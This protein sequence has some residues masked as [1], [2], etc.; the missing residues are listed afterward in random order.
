MQL[1]QTHNPTAAAAHALAVAY[2][3]HQNET[4]VCPTPSANHLVM[5]TVQSCKPIEM[6]PNPDPKPTLNLMSLNRHYRHYT[7]PSERMLQAWLLQHPPN[8][9]PRILSVIEPLAPA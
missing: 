8:P 5:Q 4:S 1:R 6:G 9:D 7:V 2:Q 3:S